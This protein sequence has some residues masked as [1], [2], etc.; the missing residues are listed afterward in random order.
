MKT[1][2][3][4]FN[5]FLKDYW[6]KRSHFSSWL[7]L[8][9]LVGLGLA[10]VAINVHINEWSKTFYDTLTAFEADKLYGLIGE[11]LIYIAIFV[12][13]AVY[14]AWLRKLLIIRWR[15][16]LTEQ[17]TGQWLSRRAFY[18]MS[19][20]DHTDNPDQR[21]AEDINVFVSRTIELFISL[22]TN[23]AQLYSFLVI[24]WKLSGTHTFHIFGHSLTVTGY[25]VWLAV[26]YTLAGSIITQLVGQKLH[27]FNYNQ[28]RFE[29]N[30]RASLLRKHDHAEQIAL[31][32]GE[33]KEQA[34]L[35][36]EFQDIIGNWRKLMNKERDL[37]FFTTAYDRFSLMLPVLA[38]VPLFMAKAITLGGLM[39]IRS[40]FSAV[41][42]SLS[43][44]VFAYSILPEW[45]ASLQRL[46]QFRQT[47]EREQKQDKPVLEGRELSFNGLNLYTPARIPVLSNIQGRIRPGAWTRLAGPSGLGKSTLLRTIGGL[48]SHYDGQWQQSPGSR[49]L[50]PQ[51]AY[52]GNGT[53]AEALS[54]P[55]EPAASDAVL[56]ELL[57]AVGLG[58]WK[59][60]LNSALNWAQTLSAGEQQ[61]LAVARAL[62]SRPDYLYL[63]EST[64]HLDETA[65]RE[66]LMLIKQR[67]PDTTV[68]MVSHQ[69]SLAD[70]YDEVLDL[71]RFKAA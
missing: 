36:R 12:V 62:L 30:F 49:L 55:N 3:T 27:R 57:E 59:A 64:S 61:R 66:V 18:R 23:L 5:W 41:F 33:A 56:H 7:L 26:A 2:L 35:R 19:L 15:S 10:V 14:R 46:S 11:Y 9:V 65:A 45:S 16:H 28:Q 53:L 63:D 39:Q 44:F 24:L 21:I 8:A 25:L 40:A 29:A 68:V 20:N 13:C 6:L 51:K 22:I 58:S 50:L 38:S 32:G 17:F 34:G 70:I 60:H 43:W 31:Y 54:Y 67:L 42:N 37:G 69:S 4:Q 52:I 48:W 47:V 71:S 1:L